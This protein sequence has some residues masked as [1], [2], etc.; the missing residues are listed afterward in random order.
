MQYFGGKQRISKPLAKYLNSVLKPDQPFVDLFCGS[1]N[2]VSKID[3][4][5]VRIAND[6]HK[7]LIAMWKHL[8]QGGDLPDTISVEDY[9]EMNKA[10]FNNTAHPDW[11]MGFVGFGCSFA[12]RY[13]E[14]Y[15]RNRAG[16]I[17]STKAKSSRNA[18]LKKIQDMKGV[19]FSQGDYKDCMIPDNSLIYCDIPYKSSTKKYAVGWFNHD[20]FYE[21]AKEKK[22]QG[23]LVLI[24]E[25][26]EN[27][28]KEFEIV[29]EIESKKSVR[30]KEGICQETTEVLITPK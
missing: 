19:I 20:E 23:H 13:F 16:D 2:V 24:S 7:E 9:Q 6:L 17:G 10:K 12:G 26:K 15:A 1:C 5:R 18:A 29:W 8:Q 27:T 14:G 22:A 4:N 25:Y 28:P 3:S 11:L 30:D 21:W